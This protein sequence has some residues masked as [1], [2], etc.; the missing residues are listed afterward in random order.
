MFFEEWDMADEPGE[1]ATRLL[2]DV[3]LI[4]DP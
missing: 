4:P 2:G 3:G 1:T